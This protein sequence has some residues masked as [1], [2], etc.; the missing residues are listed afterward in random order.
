MEKIILLVLV[1]IAKVI[2]ILL[3]VLVIVALAILFA[4]VRYC[5]KISFDDKKAQ[6][7][8]QWLGVVLRVP[9]L[10]T[11]KDLQW[12]VRVFGVP[13]LRSDGAHKK[14]RS[15][16]SSAPKAQKR[17]AEKVAETVQKTQGSSKQ[18]KKAPSVNLEKSPTA[19]EQ[20]KRIAPKQAADKTEEQNVPKKQ[21]DKTEEQIA[22]KQTTD[23]REERSAFRQADEREKK[24]RGIRQ[25]FLWLQNVIKIVRKIKKKVHSVQDLVD[26][27]RSDAGK[28]FIC[29]VKEN[30]IHLWK[31]IHPRRMR[32]KVIFGT[33]DPCSTGE[34]LG[35]L[36]LFYA[37][38]GN[39]VQIIPDFE[40]KRIE[41]NVSFRGRIRM[42]TLI[43]IAWRIIKNK[44]GRKLLHEW[45]KWKEEK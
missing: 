4:A 27:L 28:A 35:V 44:D 42:I 11:E 36:A 39:G 16:K 20:E 19:P 13:I 37:W 25:L 5:G 17:K 2:G 24:P 38:Y 6:I 12:K 18:E 43:C 34:L 9:I 26:I 1:T 21:S 33:G 30:V 14:R 45:E 41:G 40:Q 3:A 31:Q 15:K 29:I 23:Q 7:S 22:S 10:I 8:I 32:G